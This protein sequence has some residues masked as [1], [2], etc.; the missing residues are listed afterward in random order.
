MNPDKLLNALDNVL[1]DPEFKNLEKQ[2]TK[3]IL[4]GLYKLSYL[5]DERIKSDIDKIKSD[6]N[7]IETHLTQLLNKIK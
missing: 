1:N 3:T 7:V 2:D 5:R 6:I 4:L